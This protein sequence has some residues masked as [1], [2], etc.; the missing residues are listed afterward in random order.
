MYNKNKKPF[1]FFILANY[2]IRIERVLTMQ[3]QEVK[4]RLEAL[5][6]ELS[7]RTQNPDLTLEERERLQRIIANYE[8]II[9]LTDMNHFGRGK[10]VH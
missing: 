3:Y 7:V 2:Q 5:M 4:E 10:I 1:S 8:Y 9:E 6:L